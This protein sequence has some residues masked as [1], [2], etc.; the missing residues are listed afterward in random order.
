MPLRHPKSWCT[1]G[2]LLKVAQ[3]KSRTQ[4]GAQLC[5]SSSQWAKASCTLC[6]EAFPWK[7]RFK[8]WFSTNECVCC[9][10]LTRSGNIKSWCKTRYLITCHLNTGRHAAGACP[11]SQFSLQWAKK[12]TSVKS[13]GLPRKV[14]VSRDLRC[15]WTRNGNPVIELKDGNIHRK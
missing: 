5:S 8:D 10:H 6:S 2:R 4:V 1:S 3:F 15:K 12:I 14:Q 11:S 7:Y 13:G 9:K